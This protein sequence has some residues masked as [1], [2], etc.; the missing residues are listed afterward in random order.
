MEF[1]LTVGFLRAVPIGYAIRDA[2]RFRCLAGG[3]LHGDFI[4]QLE[5][6]GIQV[7][8]A[9]RLFYTIHHGACVLNGFS[10]EILSFQSGKR[11]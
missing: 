4:C 5:L 9:C 1:L 6:V 10:N 8:L 11:R 2:V 3:T 7:I